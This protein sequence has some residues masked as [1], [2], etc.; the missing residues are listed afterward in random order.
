MFT[1]KNIDS[2]KGFLYK[3]EMQFFF[4]KNISKKDLF[5]FTIVTLSESERPLNHYVYSGFF[6]TFQFY[7]IQDIICFRKC[8]LFGDH[9]YVLILY[10]IFNLFLSSMDAINLRVGTFYTTKYDQITQ[11]VF[12]AIVVA[13]LGRG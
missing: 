9:S 12:N 3:P 4:L 10:R 7:C 6:L 11:K 8:V 5:S 2:A 13:V 1:K